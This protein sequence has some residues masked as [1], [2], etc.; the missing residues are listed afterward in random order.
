[1]VSVGVVV[2]VFNKV[3]VIVLIDVTVGVL[4]NVAV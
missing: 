1:M 2:E 4:M 3:S